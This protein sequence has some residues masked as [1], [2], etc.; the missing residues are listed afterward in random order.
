VGDHDQLPGP[1]EGREN[2]KSQV[3]YHEAGEG[4]DPQ[5]RS[6]TGVGEHRA[7]RKVFATAYGME[8]IEIE[9]DDVPALSSQLE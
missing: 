6:G 4:D 8:P 3:G 7:R 2:E 9:V 5:T 1:I